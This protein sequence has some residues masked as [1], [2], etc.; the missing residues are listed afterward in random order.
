MDREPAEGIVR[1]RQDGVTTLRLSREAEHNRLDPADIVRLRTL[2]GEIAEDGS[3]AL[4]VTGTGARTF[5]SGYT[6]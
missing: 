3:L 1:S 2:F 6:L 5:S 4:I